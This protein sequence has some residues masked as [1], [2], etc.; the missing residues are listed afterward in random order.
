VSQNSRLLMCRFA[1]WRCE[2]KHRESFGFTKYQERKENFSKERT[3]GG[4]EELISVPKLCGFGTESDNVESA[5][6]YPLQFVF[7]SAEKVL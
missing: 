6:K 5:V 7:C 1:E 4:R 2:G 3:G